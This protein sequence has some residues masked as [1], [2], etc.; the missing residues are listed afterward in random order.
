MSLL[1]R[2][3]WLPLAALFLGFVAVWTCWL[4]VA[5]RHAPETSAPADHPAHAPSR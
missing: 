1:R 3:P 4:I 2:H 5:L